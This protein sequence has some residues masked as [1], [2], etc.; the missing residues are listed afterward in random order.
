[1]LF[2][3]FEA[4]VAFT[5]LSFVEH[6]LEHD[7]LVIRVNVELI[8]ADN[9]REHLLR[10]EGSLQNPMALSCAL[11]LL[12]SVDA[13]DVTCAWGFHP[14]SRDLNRNRGWRTRRW[15]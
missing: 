15:V 9:D 7:A 11:F 5:W 10:V 13:R 8:S 2:R 4:S 3:F 14:G 1:M 6:V 12:G